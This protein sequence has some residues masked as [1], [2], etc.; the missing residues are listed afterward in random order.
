[1]SRVYAVRGRHA[2]PRLLVWIV[3]PA[4]ISVVLITLLSLLGIAF[5]GPGDES[6]FAQLPYPFSIP[7]A[8]WGIYTGIGAI[9]LWFA[10]W[11]YWAKL[12]RSPLLIRL[13]WFCIMVFGLYYGA[14]IYAIHI[15]RKGDIRASEE[16]QVDGISEN[17]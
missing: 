14:L 2:I 7:L 10:M 16:S 3:V 5:F 1:M 8:I 17:E 4:A 6:I 15:W 13:G 12:D 9:G 11:V